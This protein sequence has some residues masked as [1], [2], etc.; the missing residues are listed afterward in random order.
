MNEWKM[1]GKENSP[2]E[3]IRKA[4][5]I[6]RSLGFT[7]TMKELERDL[8]DCY[9]CRLTIDGPLS[10][11]VGTNGKGMTKEL[12]HASAYG[13]MMERMENRIFSAMPRFDDPDIED[14]LND[15]FPL[16]DVWSS[17]Q[18]YVA[19]YLKQ[20]IAATV[21]SDNPL[22]SAEYLVN[23]AIEKLSP[24]KLDG[25][26][27]TMPFYSIR[28]D[29]VEY[30]PS[31]TLM[32]TGSNGLAAGNTLEE[33]MVEGL[34]EL[35]ER[36]AQMQI[37]DGNIIPP[38]IP[39]DFIAG[40]P[41]IK[42]IIDDI[43][44]SGRYKVRVMDCS[45]NRK[46]P[47]VCGAV[48]DLN[49]GGF[50]VKFG[51]QPN[52]AVAM[53][54]VFT[55]SMQGNR[56]QSFCNN[57]RPEFTKSNALLRM[58]KW[59]SIKV[60]STNMP[61]QL[62]MDDASYEFIPWGTENERSNREMMW[63]MISLMEELGSRIFV[64]DASY[65]GFP[66]VNIYATGISE[67]RPVDFLEI[68]H[69]ILWYRVQEY[70]TRIDHLSDEEV[71]DIAIFA[72]SR[73]GSV[74]EN[75]LN[76]LSQLFFNISFPFEPFDADLL[77]A[78]CMYRLGNIDECV[79]VFSYLQSVSGGMRNEDDRLFVRAVFTWMKGLAAG[80]TQE[81][82]Y[83]VVQCLYPSHVKRV[84]EIF[85]DP[86]LVLEKLYPICGKKAC[87]QITEGK[88]CYKEIHD[89]YKILFKK[90]NENPVDL[91]DIRNMLKDRI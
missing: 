89:F 36:Y 65:L 81:R 5:G 4:E 31:W 22:F 2:E 38:V 21:N 32:F 11:F 48:I 43:E 37:F 17:E 42:K 78:A 6:I 27:L 73:R 86:K 1:R 26:F 63:S 33:A 7:T 75:S 45:L 44:K 68:K 66:A 15:D 47:V 59:N 52:I 30:L 77:Y 72:A 12:S 62:L 76:S 8:E 83:Q 55:E 14:Y 69:N 29:K 84:K 50:G 57:S 3:T 18:P 82:V 85:G 58:D 54:R 34:S 90:E 46:L 41:H 39:M 25:K 49:T 53:E 10:G 28:D 56:L 87:T 70:F 13:E 79:N 61:A 71:K 91:N 74:I 23:A 60:T 51:A 19:E 9:S 40:F 24:V 67:V 16:Y 80:E 20:K 35:L 64:R 88:S